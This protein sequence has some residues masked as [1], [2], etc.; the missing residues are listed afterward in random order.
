LP[1]A[2][3]GAASPNSG[4]GAILAG[5]KNRFR[6]KLVGPSHIEFNRTARA[7]GPASGSPK[8]KFGAFSPAVHAALRQ[9]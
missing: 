1:R 7:K 6:M 3:S 8:K 5:N 2:G 9:I 4:D